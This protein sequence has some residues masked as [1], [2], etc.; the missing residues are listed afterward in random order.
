VRRWLF[1]VA[2]A[3]LIA[4]ALC[5]T[6]VNAGTAVFRPNGDPVSPAWLR[7][8]GATNW[9][10]INQTGTN[11][12]NYI[13]RNGNTATDLYDLTDEFVGQGATSITVKTY[14]AMARTILIVGNDQV[15]LTATVNG[16]PVGTAVSSVPSSTILSLLPSCPG[17]LLDLI[18]WTYGWATPASY[19]G[20]WS[21]ADMNSMKL[22]LGKIQVGGTADPIRVVRAEVEVGYIDPPSL[23]QPAYRVY[24][25]TNTVTPGVALAATN[26]PADVTNN[27]ALRVRMGTKVLSGE[28]W[29]A[30]YGS[31]KLQYAQKAASCATTSGWGDVSSS[32][33]VIRWQNNAAVADGAAISSYV[34]DPVTGG[35]VT[36]Q[37]YRES[38]NATAP[39]ATPVGQTALW[40]FSLV[41]VGGSP[42]Q[43]YCLRLVPTSGAMPLSYS[44]YPE[45]TLT[46]DLGVSIVDATGVV[47][48]SP[49]VSFGAALSGQTCQQTTGTLGTSSQRVRISNYLVKNGWSASIAATGGSSA[50]WSS[51]STGYAYNKSDG[52]PPGCTYGQLTLQP[53]SATISPSVGCLVT[54]I[55]MGS[56][57]SFMQ[58]STDA[59]TLANASSSSQRFCYWDMTNVVALQRI[60]PGLPAGVYSLDLTITVVAQ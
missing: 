11:T 13:C 3:A 20:L 16:T 44:Q 21:Q 22:S 17:T 5:D 50:N 37:Q 18:G 46:G 42:G 4:S 59:I 35:T 10:I 60:P 14:A 48:S 19:T 6:T 38:N 25:N 52:S 36:Y 49:S 1:G 7:Y 8:D 12:D 53:A 23:E 31:V 27:D 30:N 45:I 2:C 39:I 33:G 9:G 55:S 24:A 51:G 54:G 58:G 32:S 15:S 41:T 56:N 57:A 40:D 26:T 34:N 43:T 28:N 29:R 47:V